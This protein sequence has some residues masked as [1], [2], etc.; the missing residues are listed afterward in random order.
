MNRLKNI[1]HNTIDALGFFI[2]KLKSPKYIRAGKC[3]MCGTCCRNITFKISKEFIKQKEQFEVL[4]EWDKR[5]ENF[6]ITGQDN[7]GILLFTC[8]SLGND[9]KCTS[10][11]FRAWYCRAYPFVKTDFIAAGGKELD[12][13][14]F[15]FKPTK[16]FK[17]FLEEKQSTS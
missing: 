17:T 2:V 16:D 11:M 8:K 13:C 10:Y 1:L 7:E 3:K 6:Y 4:K 14:G 15:Y 9:N 12:G 5:Y